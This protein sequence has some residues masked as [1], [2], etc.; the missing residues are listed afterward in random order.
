MLAFFFHKNG[1]Q[2]LGARYMMP[3]LK[4]NKSHIKKKLRNPGTRVWAGKNV[5]MTH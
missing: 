5:G 3:L 4:G 1:N 2:S